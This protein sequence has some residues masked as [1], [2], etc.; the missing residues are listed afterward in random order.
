[1]S[2]TFDFG[3]PVTNICA[4]EN[5]STK[6]GYFVRRGRDYIECT[7]KKGKFWNVDPETVFLGHLTEEECKTL[8]E[9]IWEKR[10]GNQ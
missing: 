1:V 6:R 5:N 8:W 10:F 4:G 3:D 9:P 2:V 7:D